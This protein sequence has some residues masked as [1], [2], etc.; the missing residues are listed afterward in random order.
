MKYSGYYLLFTGII[1]NL[2]GLVMGRPILMN[3]HQEGWFDVIEGSGQ[4]LFDRSAISWFLI[5][6]FFW[7]MFGWTLQKAIEQG[8]IPPVSL[9]YSF[10][11]IGAGVA[12]L[13]PMSGAYLFI[14]QGIILWFGITK[15][16]KAVLSQQPA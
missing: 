16:Q 15:R 9:A 13:M 3:M 6:G 8:F 1:H 5:T 4:I 12:Y 14:V 7:M 10:I 11:I 2:I